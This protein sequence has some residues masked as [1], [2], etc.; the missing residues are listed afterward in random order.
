MA[1]KITCFVGKT[2]GDH[3]GQRTNRRR[4]ETRKAYIEGSG[5]KIPRQFAQNRI[6]GKR[7]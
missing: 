2:H 4:V 5:T 1:V 7:K 6:V 3:K